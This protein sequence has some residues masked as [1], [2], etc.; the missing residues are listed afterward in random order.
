MVIQNVTKNLRQEFNYLLDFCEENDIECDFDYELFSEEGKDINE[1]WQIGILLPETEEYEYYPLGIIL[2]MIATAENAKKVNA[3][4]FISKDVALY[5]IDSSNYLEVFSSLSDIPGVIEIV[6]GN[7]YHIEIIEGLTSYGFAITMKGDYDEVFPPVDFDDSFIEIKCYNGEIDEKI[8]ESLVQAYIFEVK[9]T[10]GIEIQINPRQ[11]AD[12]LE[13]EEINSRSEA[14]SRL[15]P[16]LRGKGIDGVLKLYN[17]SLSIENG[18]FLILTYTKVIEYVSQTVIQ[19][20]LISSVS[21][22]LS[23]P[24]ALMPDAGY[25]LGLDQIFEKHRNNKKEQLAIRLT[26]QTCCD[27]TEIISFAPSFLKN[28]KKLIKDSSEENKQKAIEEIAAAINQTRNMFA[29]A[30]T[31]YVKKGNECPENQLDEF[32]KCMDILAQQ[33]IRWFAR[34]HENNRVV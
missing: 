27:I 34:E 29:H 5:R 3:S 32:A 14:I 22:K 11:Y 17:S 1:E 6:D 8:I 4:T 15:R 28:T 19:E 26:L 24:K 9:S 31:N 16:L 23:S 18:E 10:L 30:K 25:I 12:P 20:D 33:V 21:K 7:E 13:K 2:D